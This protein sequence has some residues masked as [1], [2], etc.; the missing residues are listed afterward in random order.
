MTLITLAIFAVIQS[1]HSD[2]ESARSWQIGDN[3]RLSSSPM[4]AGESAYVFIDI[5][6]KIIAEVRS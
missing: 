1:Y 6:R 5:F 4:D 3:S 2:G